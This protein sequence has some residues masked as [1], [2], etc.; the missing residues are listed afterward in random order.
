M[1]QAR[2]KGLHMVWFYLCEMSTIGKQRLGNF[3]DWT[4]L[5]GTAFPFG[6]MKRNGWESE[7]MAEQSN[8]YNKTHTIDYFKKAKTL[9]KMCHI[10]VLGSDVQLPDN[11]NPQDS[12]GGSGN[13]CHTHGR[14]GLSFPIPASARFKPK[15]VDLVGINVR[16]LSVCLS[17]KSKFS[18]YVNQISQKQNLKEAVQQKWSWIIYACCGTSAVITLTHFHRLQ[19]VRNMAFT[20]SWKFSS[21]SKFS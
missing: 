12:S 7:M 10:G 21:P 19:V 4:M 15:T 3:G 17:K 8:G 9:V 16:S 20:Y 5:V 14:P 13:S 1:T 18:G 2:C 11:T 6:V